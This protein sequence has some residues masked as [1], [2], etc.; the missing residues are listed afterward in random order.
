MAE[1]PACIGMALSPRAAT[2][3]SSSHRPG[4]LEQL[5][6]ALWQAADGAA[7]VGA[8][9]PPSKAEPTA[10]DTVATGGSTQ[11]SARGHALPG[12]PQP[13]TGQDRACPKWDSFKGQP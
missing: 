8:L 5:S 4:A 10:S 7:R 13:R 3:R 9:E 1:E 6:G 12:S 2:D 11:P